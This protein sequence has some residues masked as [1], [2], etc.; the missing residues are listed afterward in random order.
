MKYS[1]YNTKFTILNGTIQCFN[2]CTELTTKFRKFSSLI[3]KLIHII[4]TPHCP[5][6]QPLTSTSLLSVSLDLAILNISYK[7]SYTIGGPFWSASSTSIMFSILC[8]ISIL[9]FQYFISFYGWI[10]FLC[11]NILHYIYLPINWWTF[12]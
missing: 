6:P 10:I 4:F 5:C 3:K 8:S 11:V 7:T 1:L 9:V 12:R 2:I